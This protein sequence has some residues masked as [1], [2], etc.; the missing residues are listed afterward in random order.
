MHFDYGFDFALEGVAL[1]VTLPHLGR[2]SVHGLHNSVRLR[3]LVLDC[4][5]LTCL[6]SSPLDASGFH[7]CS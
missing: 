3:C 1:L 2:S 7:C 4:L 6:E 5:R